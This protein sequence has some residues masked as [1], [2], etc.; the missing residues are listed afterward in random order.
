MVTKCSLSFEI[1]YFDLL[2]LIKYDKIKRPTQVTVFTAIDRSQELISSCYGFTKTAR[3]LLPQPSKN[4][5]VFNSVL[6]HTLC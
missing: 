1:F 5:K 2:V 3:K 4:K 6:H